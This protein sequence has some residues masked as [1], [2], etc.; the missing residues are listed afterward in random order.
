MS[1][2]IRA[3]A[4]DAGIL[5]AGVEYV[6]VTSTGVSVPAATAAAHALRAG[7][8]GSQLNGWTYQ[9]SGSDIAIAA[10]SGLDSTRAYFITGAAL[11][12]TTGAWA[13]GNNA[14]GLDTGTIGNND[15]YIWAIARSD[16]GVVD[17][18]FSLS[19]TAPTMPASYNYARLIGWF[20]RAGGVNVAFHTYETNGGGI[21]FAWD[22]PALDINLSN[23]LTTSRRT[24]ALRVP[25]NF[26]VI[27]NIVAHIIDASAPC[28]INICCPDQT[29]VAP[30][31]QA[32]LAV[33]NA[34]TGTNAIAQLRIRTSSAGL[35]AS[36]SNL[37][38]VD[39]YDVSTIGFE[40]A[41][42]V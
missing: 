12:K 1:A 28:A 6:T 14:G 29:D 38:T 18:L 30:G 37:A 13:A 41:R 17:Y 35:I 5:V 25:L 24:D 21:E 3:G 16:T 40:W 26:S 34:P 19:S 7:Q 27:A 33:I 39:T 8:Y 20:K 11:T 2:S 15:Y 23:T 22:A 32:N 9:N 36:R 42:R 10:G 31:Y 4:S